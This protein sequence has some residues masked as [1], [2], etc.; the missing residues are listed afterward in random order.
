M[1]LMVTALVGAAVGYHLRPR[2]VQFNGGDDEA[3]IL[4]KL[5]ACEK[6]LREISQLLRH[7]QQVSHLYQDLY[8]RSRSAS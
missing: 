7:E 5:D 6:K 4:A 8:Q 3:V 1:S 2:I